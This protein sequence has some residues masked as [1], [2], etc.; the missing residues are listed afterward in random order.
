MRYDGSTTL[1]CLFSLSREKGKAGL[2]TFSVTLQNGLVNRE[3]IDRKTDSSLA[4]EDHWLVKDGYIAYNMM[5]MWQGASALARRFRRGLLRRSCS[6]SICSLSSE[7]QY[8]QSICI[9]FIQNAKNDLLIL[10]LFIW[11][12]E[13]QT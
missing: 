13:G 12:N 10:G 3:S 4:P 7:E 6:H 9:L 2:T 1:G 5:R 11:L 8:R